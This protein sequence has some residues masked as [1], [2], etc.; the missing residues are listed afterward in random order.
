MGSETSKPSLAGTA[1][2]LDSGLESRK[3]ATTVSRGISSGAREMIAE[4]TREDGMVNTA[5]HWRFGGQMVLLCGSFTNWAQT[6][7]LERQ[8]HEFSVIL[9]L[10]RGVYLYKF[11]VD[12]EWRFS[13]DDAKATDENG[14]INNIVDTT[15]FVPSVALK[16]KE[17]TEKVDIEK[18]SDQQFDDEAPQAPPQISENSL[19]REFDVRSRLFNVRES[20]LSP[21][22]DKYKV[23]QSRVVTGVLHQLSALDTPANVVLN[24]LGVRRRQGASNEE[25]CLVSSVTQRYRCKYVTY[26]FHTTSD[27]SLL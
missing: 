14:N 26:K 18:T 17:K 11:V 15:K 20:E 16:D 13:P 23:S 8:G 3:T 25:Q 27:A 9:R 4:G 2:R 24:H 21:A 22:E 10:P 1:E 7:V 5:F 6:I 12:G 19:L